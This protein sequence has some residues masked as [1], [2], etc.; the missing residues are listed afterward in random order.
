MRRNYDRPAPSRGGRRIWY[1]VVLAFAICDQLATDIQHAYKKHCMGQHAM[2]LN[3]D[4]QN[5]VLIDKARMMLHKDLCSKW[6]SYLA[7]HCGYD[8][9]SMHDYQNI[10]KWLE[11][12]DESKK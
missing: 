9:K 7:E 11:D 3:D 12:R 8:F 10:I 4:R 2:Y 5:I 1:P 6:I